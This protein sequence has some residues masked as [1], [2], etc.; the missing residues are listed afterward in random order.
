[1][2]SPYLKPRF[3]RAPSQRKAFTLI[4]LLVVI[5]IIAILAAILF[6]VF[7]QAR[8]KARAISCLSNMKQVGTG[9]MM[10]FQDYDETMLQDWYGD[11]RPSDPT[12][13]WYKWMDAVYPY[14]KNEQIFNCPSHSLNTKYVYYKRLTAPASNYGSYRVNVTYHDPSDAWNPPTSGFGNVVTMARLQVPADTVF[15]VDA[16]AEPEW[17]NFPWMEWWSVNDAPTGIQANSNPK[18]FG[19]EGQIE[20]RH[21]DMTN[22]IF[23][24]GH[25]KAWKLENLI[26]RS[27]LPANQNFRIYKYFTIEDD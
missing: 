1:M 12:R 6:P 5:A 26:T 15:V 24:D 25:A 16:V 23:A 21:N 14:V 13:E 22:V 4:E 20:A 3:G 19:A 18:R 17:H 9:M 2:R 10:Y 8:E 7:A 27:T 11:W